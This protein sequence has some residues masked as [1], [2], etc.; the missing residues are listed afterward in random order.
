MHLISL[1]S[2]LVGVAFIKTPTRKIG[3]GILLKAIEPIT[4]RDVTFA[5]SK[6]HSFF[7]NTG[8]T[9]NGNPLFAFLISTLVEILFLGLMSGISQIANL[10]TIFT[11]Y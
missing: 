8:S 6:I 9:N 4:F 2:L 5:E 1:A 10:K 3:P 11:V 7:P